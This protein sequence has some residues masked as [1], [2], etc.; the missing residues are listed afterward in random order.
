MIWNECKSTNMLPRVKILLSSFIVFVHHAHVSD[1]HQPHGFL[2]YRDSKSVICCYHSYQ[3]PLCW[4][5]RQDWVCPSLSVSEWEPLLISDPHCLVN[6]SI[7]S[8]IFT[9]CDL[10]NCRLSLTFA[11]LSSRVMYYSHFFDSLSLTL[12]VLST[13]FGFVFSMDKSSCAISQTPSDFRS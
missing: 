6:D 2:H 9:S 12:F 5:L 11:Y 8:I 7:L 10:R 3:N 4:S 1:S 13:S